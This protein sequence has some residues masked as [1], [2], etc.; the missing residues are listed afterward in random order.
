MNEPTDHLAYD[1]C[2]SCLLGQVEAGSGRLRVPVVHSLLD[3]EE[4]FEK[5]SGVSLRRLISR[6]SRVE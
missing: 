6:A 5:A 2:V 3:I 4:R 1:T